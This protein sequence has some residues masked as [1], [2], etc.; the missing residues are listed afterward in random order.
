MTISA[1][2]CASLDAI[3]IDDAY[4]SRYN[5]FINQP[6][7]HGISEKE[8]LIMKK[9]IALALATLMA[10]SLFAGCGASKATET[11]VLKVSI[12]PDFAPMEFVIYNEA[13]S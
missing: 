12:S 1:F 10:L 5:A 13:S 11:P 9:I 8:N 2:S 6:A 4:Y 7:D 3:P